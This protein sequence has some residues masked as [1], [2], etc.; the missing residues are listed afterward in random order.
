[1]VYYHGIVMVTV[2]MAIY[3]RCPQVLN[4]EKC[5]REIG[6][7]Q[8]KLREM[9]VRRILVCWDARLIPCLTLL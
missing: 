6:R 3:T 9:C 1:M 8:E 2:A 4:T 5:E 7:K